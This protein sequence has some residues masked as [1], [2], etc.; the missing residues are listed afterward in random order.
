M[1]TVTPEFSLNLVDKMIDIIEFNN[2]EEAV[3]LI[4][5]EIR[6]MLAGKDSTESRVVSMDEL[7]LMMNLSDK[8]FVISIPLSKGVMPDE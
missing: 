2:I 1:S 7:I 5:K 3:S 4:D 6:S 8:D